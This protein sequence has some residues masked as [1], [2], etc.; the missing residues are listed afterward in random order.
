MIDQFLSTQSLTL[1]P[2]KTTF[3]KLLQFLANSIWKNRQILTEADFHDGLDRV[4]ELTFRPGGNST[5]HFQK[6]TAERPNIAFRAILFLF[7]YFGGH[8]RNRS[9]YFMF[10]FRIQVG[11]STRDLLRATEIQDFQV[12]RRGNQNVATF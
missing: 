12:F 5:A 8:P 6:Q 1:F 9:F 2:P 3:D 10:Q 7:N 11:Q 4:I